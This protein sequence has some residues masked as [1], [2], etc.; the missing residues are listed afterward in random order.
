[1]CLST[2]GAVAAHCAPVRCSMLTMQRAQPSSGDCTGKQGVSPQNADQM[3]P[4]GALTEQN[5]PG[6]GICWDGSIGA[7]SLRAY[8]TLLWGLISRFARQGAET[9]TSFAVYFESSVYL[10]HCWHHAEMDHFA[11]QAGGEEIT[12]QGHV[13]KK[14]PQSLLEKIL[15]RLHNATHLVIALIGLQNQNETW[16][17]TRLHANIPYF[18]HLNSTLLLWF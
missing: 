3:A 4:H 2:L 17:S 13:L 15:D 12:G 14:H 5:P 18:A 10:R 6:L 8:F 1:L 7:S 11:V 9:R 16:H